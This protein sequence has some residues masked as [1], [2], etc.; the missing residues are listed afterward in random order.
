M[1]PDLLGFQS[2]H[3]LFGRI[4]R[5]S[6]RPI[7]VRALVCSPPEQAFFPRDATNID[8]LT[9]ISSSQS[10]QSFTRAMEQLPT[11]G[12]GGEPSVL[13][14]NLPYREK[15]SHIGSI[16]QDA[17]PSEVLA[18]QPK[19]PSKFLTIPYIGILAVDFTGPLLN[20]TAGS[21][22]S[23]RPPIA[24][25]APSFEELART[26]EPRSGE[27]LRVPARLES[28]AGPVRASNNLQ[29]TALCDSMGSAGNRAHRAGKRRILDIYDL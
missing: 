3:L 12:R 11:C 2:T 20:A 8:D 19:E 22:E 18:D 4:G 24:T 1:L 6:T 10:E 16:D 23:W 15:H 7:N 29:P 14:W 13:E 25:S 28:L 17:E 9:D 21:T 26:T 5:T 27:M